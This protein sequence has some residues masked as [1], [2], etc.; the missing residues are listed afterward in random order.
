MVNPSHTG[1]LG[2][3]DGLGYTLGRARAAQLPRKKGK[4]KTLSSMGAVL[5][6]KDTLTPVQQAVGGSSVFLAVSEVG[7]GSRESVPDFARP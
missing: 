6:E 2:T 5:R 4:N 1:E 7:L 3:Q